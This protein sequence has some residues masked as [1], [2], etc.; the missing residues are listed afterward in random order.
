MFIQLLRAFADS[1]V[2]NGFRSTIWKT[3]L[4][5][6]KDSSLTSTYLLEEGVVIPSSFIEAP[7]NIKPEVRAIAFYLPQF[8]RIPENDRWWGDGF[9]EWSNV[10]RAKS[11]FLYHYQPQ[12]PH[13]DLGYYDLSDESIM[14]KQVQMAGQSG[15]YGF[16]FYY[17][18]FSGKRL[19]E[20][21]VDRLLQTK[22]PDFPF[23]L[24]WA[25]ES[26]S[27]RWDGNDTQDM[28]VLIAQK[29]SEQDSHDFILNIIPFFKDK[30]YI[31]VNGAPLFL[32]YRPQ[33]IPQA[34]KVFDHWRRICRQEGVGEIHLAG[35]ASREYY[36]FE[37]MG[38]NALI[39][40]PPHR[41]DGSILNHIN[42]GVSSDF[43][44]KIYDYRQ[45]RN[46]FLKT[47][48]KKSLVY[49]GLMSSWDNTARRMDRS[50]AFVGSS[51]TAYY[52]WLRRAVE[53]TCQ[54]RVGDERLL[55]I[56]AWNEW[57]EGCHL[58]P[59]E[60]D[61]YAWLNATRKAILGD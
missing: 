30:R 8:H 19:L 11:Y 57:A 49:R 37:K 36:D 39:E 3:I 56:N 46:N 7:K 26:W 35:V 58:E 44:G 17:Y 20:M 1:L 42:Y 2:R 6:V 48:Y 34:E 24:C 29:Y 18:W 38:M 55:F 14:E 23:C 51:P 60:R 22:R 53:L 21:P 33:E 52:A 16:C 4:Y 27:R 31:R 43:K 12:V 32:V 28:E 40:F 47:N 10:R 59:D 13:S 61:G 9:T 45:I 5:L 15:I 25:N 54:Q 41:I 50:L